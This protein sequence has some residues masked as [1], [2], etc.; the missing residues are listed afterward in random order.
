MESTAALKQHVLDSIV[1]SEGRT[2]Q[3]AVTA[4]AA[5]DKRV[6]AA[7]RRATVSQ[8]WATESQAQLM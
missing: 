4:Q 1:A 7:E 3:R 8:Q 6:D 2:E 5:A